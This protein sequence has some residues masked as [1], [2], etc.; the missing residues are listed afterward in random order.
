MMNATLPLVSM[1][2]EASFFERRDDTAVAWLG[3][4]G[5]IINARG[6]IIVIDPLISP[7]SM[8][9][10]QRCE[11]GLKLKI[12]LPIEAR[13]LPRLDA[14]LITHREA[15]HYGERTARHFHQ[16]LNPIFVGPPPVA[17]ALRELRVQ[18]SQLITAHDFQTYQIG[19]AEITVTPALHDH[20]PVTPWK[21]GDCVG[22]R[23]KTPDATIWHPGD[24]RLIDELLEIRDVDVLLFDVADV[25]AH[26]GPE[27]SARLAQSS[28][29]KV[30]IAY[31]YGTYDL[32]PGGWANSDPA[33]SWPYVAGL[34]V[35]LL[36]LRPGEPLRL[37]Q[38]LSRVE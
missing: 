11:S 33:A 12:A 18:E 13:E 1:P 10:G 38:D 14:M 15:D 29:A 22:Y 23:V 28:G 9:G 31:H 36:M 4:A 16:R 20:D 30:A 7:E 24:T 5:C 26:L 8:D 3:M 19:S 32:P 35:R 27:G 17:E 6:T 34:P 37:P 25:I 2:I 21:R